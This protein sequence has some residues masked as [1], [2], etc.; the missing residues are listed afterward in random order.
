MKQRLATLKAERQALSA[1]NSTAE[2]AKLDVLLHPRLPELYRR[3][4]E[5]LER[6]L[7]GADRAEAMDLIRSMIERVDITPRA[8]GTGVDAVLHGA[9]AAILEA[10]SGAADKQNLPGAGERPG[11]QLSVV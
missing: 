6:V 9:L 7:E 3:K 11:S 2:D 1:E 4:V 5:E 8:D 10:C